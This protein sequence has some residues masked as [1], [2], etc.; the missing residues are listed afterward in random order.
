MR[1]SARG[2]HRVLHLPD[3]RGMRASAR[4]TR[5]MPESVARC[6]MDANPRS[7]RP[8]SESIERRGM[9]RAVQLTVPDATLMAYPPNGLPF[10][11]PPLRELH[12]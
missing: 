3:R 12:R 7:I 6:G 1:A 4:G 5:L 11:W 9:R 10:S 8:T 2:M